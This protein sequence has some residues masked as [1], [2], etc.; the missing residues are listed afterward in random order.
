[1]TINGGDLLKLYFL[2]LQVLIYLIPSMIKF[3][4]TRTYSYSIQARAN[5]RL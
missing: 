4:V 1:M 3:R 2:Q 5:T